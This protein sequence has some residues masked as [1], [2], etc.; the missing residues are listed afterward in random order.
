M[1][2]LVAEL[3]RR[4]VF[5]VVVAY[6][7]VGWILIQAGEVLF[8]SF[9]APDWV[10]KVFIVVVAL[11]FPL[12]IVLAW[13]LELT[14]QGLVTQNSLDGRA[15]EPDAA[16]ETTAERLSL[17]VLPFN[18]MSDNPDYDH[19]A[20]GM[21]EDLTTFLSRLP[22]VSVVARNSTFAYKGQSPDIRQVGRE[23]G[24]RYVLEGS[25]RSLGPRVRVVAQLIE[26]ETGTHVWAN[27]FDV[28]AAD[29]LEIQDEMLAG[30][31]S[32][33]GRQLGRAESKRAHDQDEDQL[34]AWGWIMR[35]HW[36]GRTPSVAATTEMARCARKALEIDP[37]YAPAYGLL[38]EAITH[39]SL[40][41]FSD[42]ATELRVEAM[43][44]LEKAE[45]IDSQNPLV[46]Q[47]SGIVHVNL[48]DKATG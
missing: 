23:L 12:A 41:T 11:G 32:A 37:S 6:L 7:I 26:T 47:S 42:K 5:K 19:L 40:N 22:N 48:G 36:Y 29:I 16:Q 9:G 13:A 15:E 34:D 39:E 25:V 46:M 4:N 45:E 44:M 21:S 20:D 14:P 1:G 18:N 8:P 2:N 33:V 28:A 31:V 3:R 27:N 17:A 43:A 30:I 35:A 10:L 24:I 38:A